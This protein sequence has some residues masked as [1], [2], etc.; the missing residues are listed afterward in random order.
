MQYI[1][2]DKYSKPCNPSPPPNISC[3]ILPHYLL[4]PPLLP[5]IIT[6]L[7]PRHHLLVQLNPHQHQT[8]SPNCGLSSAMPIPQAK[9]WGPKFWKSCIQIR[10][11]YIHW[12]NQQEEDPAE[13]GGVEVVGQGNQE[14]GAVGSLQHIKQEG[15]FKFGKDDDWG[16]EEGEVWEICKDINERKKPA[17]DV[18]L[19]SVE[20]MGVDMIWCIIMEDSHTVWAVVAVGIACLVIKRMYIEN[21]NFWYGWRWLWISW[22]M[23]WL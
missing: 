17:S 8:W 10:W 11:I 15:H 23:M 4:F 14:E 18:Y 13:I 22:G 20:T 16:G 9:R 2:N 1:Q 21:N 12:A 19:M 7:N 5:A 3:P 6:Y